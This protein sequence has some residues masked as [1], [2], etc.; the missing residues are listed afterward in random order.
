LQAFSQNPRPLQIKAG[1]VV[2][3]G[4]TPTKEL[5]L[6]QLD[7]VQ[8][9]DSDWYWVD[10]EAALRDTATEAQAVIEWVES[11]RK[12]AI[13]TSNDV[14]TESVN[15]NS[16]AGLNKGLYERTAIF[17]D[18]DATNYGGFA[19]AASLGTR[20]FDDAN[21]AYTAKFK[22]LQGLAPL[23]KSS[24]IIQAITGFTPQIGQ[25]TTT[26][27]MANCIIDIGDQFFVV[28]GSTLTPNVFIDEIHASDWIIAR[29]EEEMLQILLNNARISMD[30]D[31]M[32]TLAAGPR[33]IMQLASRSG[34]IARDLDLNGDY[35]N[36]YEITVP[37]VFDITEAQRKNRIAPAIAVRFRYAGAVHYTTV[38]YQMTF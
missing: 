27:N 1:F 15:T 21:S 31:G 19:L 6:A 25:A 18:T 2:V 12:I 5:F 14:D 37:S 10:V 36:S 22:K 8:A 24:A 23:N 16:V 13:L 20:V 33:T 9:Y 34:L 29:T 38:N 26:G 3:D 32:E 4:E 11:K 30:D 35:Q 17:Y 7:L 28:E